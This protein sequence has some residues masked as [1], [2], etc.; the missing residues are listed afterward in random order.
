VGAYPDVLFTQDSNSIEVASFFVFNIS[1][2]WKYMLTPVIMLL[3]TPFHACKD[4]L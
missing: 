4:H 3:L 1:Q 2:F